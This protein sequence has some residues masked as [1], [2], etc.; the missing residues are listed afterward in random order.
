MT[1]RELTGTVLR[2]DG[3]PLSRGLL[4]AETIEPGPSEGG[5]VVVG[6]AEYRVR[7]GV[8]K[9]P[10][11][12][13]DA[14]NPPT[15][16]SPANYKFRLTSDSESV[17]DPFDA[18]VAESADPLD[19]SALYG[20]AHAPV[21]V[22]G[23][24]VSDHGDLDGLADDD[25]P[26]Y[27][28]DARGDAR[29]VQGPASAADGELAQF[30][31][32]TGRQIEG[33]GTTLAAV[34]GLISAK[35]TPADITT[36]IDALKGGAS[37]AYDTL[38]E[39]EGHFGSNATAIAALTTL[40]GEKLAKS[41]NLSDLTNAATA[42]TNLSLGTAALLDAPASGNATSGQVVKGDDTRLMGIGRMYYP[43]DYGAV[44]GDFSSMQASGVRTANAAAVQAALEDAIAA[45]GR[46]MF[47]EFY[48]CDAGVID[49]DDN[50][51]TVRGI[52]D[53]WLAGVGTPDVSGTLFN[54]TNEHFD[55]EGVRFFG[56]CEFI[57]GGAA[58]NT[59][60]T[61]LFSA[62][63]TGGSGANILKSRF[64]GN[65]CLGGGTSAKF[66][67]CAWTIVQ[68]NAFQHGR[69][70]SV[71]IST[72]A[73]SD[74]GD[75]FFILNY[76]HAANIGSPGYSAA[77][78]AAMRVT[79][80]SG[81]YVIANKFF[82]QSSQTIDVNLSESAFEAGGG[83][84]QIA[85]MYALNQFDSGGN[86]TGSACI[87]YRSAY[88]GGG[89]GTAVE[90]NKL[91]DL[92]VALNFASNC[93][94]LLDISGN[95]GVFEDVRCMVN[96]SSGGG[97]FAFAGTIT[98]L[99]VFGNKFRTDASAF[100]PA[101]PIT[102]TATITEKSIF[103]NTWRGY[104]S[105]SDLA[106]DSAGGGGSAAPIAETTIALASNAAT[107]TPDAGQAGPHHAYTVIDDDAT[108]TIVASDGQLGSWKI[109]YSGDGHTLAFAATGKTIR[110]EGGS[111]PTI[112]SSA[113]DD[114]V[115]VLHFRCEGPD[116]VCRYVTLGTIE[117]YT[118]EDGGSDLLDFS[119]LGV[120]PVFHLE[121]THGV[122]DAD[123]G[124]NEVTTDATAVGRWEDQ[125]GNNRHFTQ[126][127]SGSRPVY[128]TN[129]Q[130]SLPS[131]RFTAASNHF[132]SRSFSSISGPF[133]ILL[134]MGKSNTTSNQFAFYFTGLYFGAGT[135]WLF[136][137]GTTLTT[138]ET[139]A[140]GVKLFALR[141][142]GANGKVIIDDGTP[143]TL[144]MTGNNGTISAGTGHIGTIGSGDRNIDADI[145]AMIVLPG[146]LSDT[147]LDTARDI[148]N[149]K[150]ALW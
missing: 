93:V 23:G 75:M 115:D 95:A 111:A 31:G 146:S 83:V 87:K 53:G 1:S 26:Q 105:A 125:S 76:V 109:A 14:D 60:T 117:D 130:G 16:E 25:H 40:I 120:T 49:S 133:T 107:F 57:P 44:A 72:P 82:C 84:Q 140:T 116:L 7:A 5:V 134:V 62:D 128:K 30:D 148:V 86:V 77:N 118:L 145:L 18:G 13:A 22:P 34:L 64:V 46:L 33:A 139:V 11:S 70:E 2:P 112:P 141:G 113:V 32:V 55:V 50:E 136:N 94:Q 90:G 9:H 10:T 144:D 147:D 143:T 47:T 135:N 54:H 51:I 19:W 37:S 6:R 73:S 15:I 91:R 89:S 3:Q 81:L 88:G 29:Y 78:G 114:R 131:L 20:D 99:D 119:S 43:Q 79:S 92:T 61:V 137:T 56:P 104:A 12:D 110:W 108:L 4:V 100:A 97:G 67:N 28:N 106:E 36:A 98:C 126:A 129:I 149:A 59:Y 150:Y 96:V 122:Y 142:G 138:T 74:I 103:G 58:S 69:L 52:G 127:T 71:H 102:S 80:C 45:R 21:D 27:H 24:G 41:A 124:G 65:N 101:K 132:I 42:R 39:L 66:R 85:H 38:I 35:A 63:H 123:T 8:I 121:A 17:V 68:G 48:W